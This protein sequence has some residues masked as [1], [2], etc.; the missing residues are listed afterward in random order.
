MSTSSP[1]VMLPPGFGAAAAAANMPIMPAISTT[2][3]TPRRTIP[4]PMA[5]SSRSAAEFLP[6]SLAGILGRIALPALR[7]RT[8]PRPRRAALH[9]RPIGDRKH[10]LH[11]IEPQR[12]AADQDALLPPFDALD[13]ARGGLVRAVSGHA[14]EIRNSFG[15][16]LRIHGGGD[17]RAPGDSR[18]DVTG[19][20]DR[21]ADA[22][23]LELV[24]QRLG[25]AA[26]RELACRIG[27]LAGGC[28]DAE[29][30]REVDDL[31]NRLPPQHRQE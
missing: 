5:G 25:K 9:Q 15:R 29:D 22:A 31:R 24:P 17:P 16:L 10:P 18:P 30:A 8:R 12:I 19:M 21:D 6:P 4:I 13:D 23:V 3:A 2:C 20:H 1:T 26:D 11:P 27:G 28:D 7:R 14:V